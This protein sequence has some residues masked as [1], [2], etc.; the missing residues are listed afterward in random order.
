M[1]N[2]K[3]NK[4]KAKEVMEKHFDN[5]ISTLKQ[6]SA[7]HL[8]IKIEALKND[9]EKI[10]DNGYTQSSQWNDI[11]E[12]AREISEEYSKYSSKND[13][14]Y[15]WFIFYKLKTLIVFNEKFR[16]VLGKDNYPKLTLENLR[17]AILLTLRSH[18]KVIKASKD[19]YKLERYDKL[20][21]NLKEAI[22]EKSSYNISTSRSHKAIEEMKKAFWKD[23]EEILFLKECLIWYAQLD[24]YDRMEKVL[25]F[26]GLKR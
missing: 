18:R 21:K 1:E 2:I 13:M 3:N 4:L 20:K 22:S 16:S 8:I 24:A 15:I 12:R 25:D 9:F 5:S 10:V 17:N 6:V 23:D 11:E 14:K 7:E 26:S 19:L